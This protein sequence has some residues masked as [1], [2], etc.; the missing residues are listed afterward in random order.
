MLTKATYESHIYLVTNQYIL[1][2]FI[3]ALSLFQ[4][5]WSSACFIILSPIFVS[6]GYVSYVHTLVWAVQE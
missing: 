6:T 1:T 5:L 3:F 2:G 4:E